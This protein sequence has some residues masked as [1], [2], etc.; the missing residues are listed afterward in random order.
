M[1][2]TAM[3]TRLAVLVGAA[4]VAVLALSGLAWAATTPLAVTKTVP[5]SGATEV[6]RT[7]NVKAY[8]NHDM[9]ASTV[10]SSTFK[11]RK[12]GTTT[13]LGATRSVNNT[14]S[15]TSTNGSSQSVVTLNPNSDLAANTTYQVV[16]LGG[17]SGV[18][19][20]NGNALS[21]NKS[22]TFTT[23]TLPNTTIDP[24]SGPTGTVAST[25]AS[26]AFS[27]S[28]PISTFQ[29]SLDGSTFAACTSPKDYPGPLS[30]GNHTFRVM[31][32]DASGTQDPTPA[33]RSWT[34]DTLAPDAPA[35]TS[36][37]DK[38]VVGVNFTLSGTA[39]P[40][41]A[42][43]VFEGTTS[44][45]NTQANGSGV[46]SKVLSGVSE[47]AHTYAA[48]ATD[49]AG[50]VSLESESRTLTVDATAPD[51][52]ITAKP[53]DPSN[54]ASPSFSF[55]STEANST[56]ECQRDAG[57]Y[58]ACTSPK[59]YTGISDGSHTF[60]V[61]A[62]DGAGNIDPTPAS[63]AWTVDAT[64]PTVNNVSPA[65]AATAN[66]TT[67]VTATFSEAMNPTS[68]SA[69][70]FT[71]SKAGSPVSAQVTYD[72]NSRSATLVPAQ[73][74]EPG[75]TYDAKITTSV[76]DA[77]G[78]ALVLARTWS[79][80]TKSGVIV[81]PTTLNLSI[82]DVLFCSPHGEWVTVTNNGPGDV[83]VAAVSITGTDAKYFSSGSQSYLANNGPLPVPAGDFFQ[84]QVAFS[85]GPTPTERNSSK[86][87]SATLTYKDGNGGTIGSPVSLTA[88]AHCLNFG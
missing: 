34:V 49:A 32:I 16:V 47:G 69:Q 72:G 44:Q 4:L 25:S 22:W 85:A 70:S 66:V 29:C 2:Q 52:S 87:Y 19:D 71:L 24:N 82:T 86:V 46:W 7:V 79:F 68:I 39:E 64:P 78:N 38:G 23:V 84:D 83:T 43:E 75:T 45:G 60:S 9:K 63:Y 67:N 31:A 33:S 27:S 36:P 53:N 13:W 61:R 57:T 48:K 21:T 54:N 41:A 73:S 59:S 26:F 6:S 58:G 20:V 28:K 74:L 81:S 3:M 15:P 5:G 50:N 80:T 11:I 77:A 56:F 62:I 42:V 65:N 1:K 12:Q 40:N 8:F 18:K 35:I 17:S 14:I 55:S 76:T 37:Q 30:Q 10:T 88:E 51:T